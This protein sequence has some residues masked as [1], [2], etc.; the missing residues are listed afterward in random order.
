ME[1]LRSFMVIYV[2]L[3]LNTNAREPLARRSQLSVNYSKILVVMNVRR[4]GDASD[5][6]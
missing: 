5:Y 6:Y 2:F 1:N 3:L 4:N